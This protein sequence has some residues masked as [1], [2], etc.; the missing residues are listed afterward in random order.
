MTPSDADIE[1]GW[2]IFA[3]AQHGEEIAWRVLISHYRPRLLAIAALV[4]GNGATAEDVVQETFS[5]SLA[6]RVRN[7]HGTVRG[8]LG[9]IA[10]RL[11]V[12][13]TQRNRRESGA[14]DERITDPHPNPLDA[15]I[16]DERD[17][18][19]AQAI[20]ALADDQRE[21]MVL[22]FYG[23]HSYEE[24]SAALD[25]PVGTAKSRVFYAVKS[26]REVLKSKGVLE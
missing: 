22:R 19:V 9:T 15:L 26:C 1:P 23:G 10:F 5:R 13:A 21:A 11:A 14:V 2:D 16:D 25:I 8:L 12:K 7:H 18:A 6:V 3:R 24:I 20:R 17:R 4:T